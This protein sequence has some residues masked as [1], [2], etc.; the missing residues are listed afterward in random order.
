MRL[1]NTGSYE[2]KEFY[3]DVPKYAIL[4]HTWYSTEEEVIF[5]DLQKPEVAGEKTK[6]WRKVKRACAY[7]QMYQF[8][9]IW[10]DSCCINKESSAELSEAINSMFQYY[11][12]AEICYVYL[13][14]VLA[15]EDPRDVKS[16]FRQSRWFK[17]GWTLQ[18]LLA[19]AYVEFL[20][21]DW[22]KI[23][24]KWSLCDAISAI[25]TIPHPVLKNGDLDK[26]S[27]AQKMSWAAMRKTTRAEDQAYCLMGLFGVSMPPIYGEGGAKAFMRLQQEIIKISEDRSIFAWI[28]AADDGQPRGLLARSP[29][30]FR[31]SGDVGISD[32]DALDT[33]SSFSFNNNGL[34]IHLPLIPVKKNPGVFQASLH[35]R[36]GGDGR[37]LS[38]YLQEVTASSGANRYVRSYVQEVRLSSSPPTTDPKSLREVVIKEN[39]LSQRLMRQKQSSLTLSPQFILPESCT[40]CQDLDWRSRPI[41]DVSNGNSIYSKKEIFRFKIQNGNDEEHFSIAI[42]RHQE[43]HHGTTFRLFTETTEPSV[44]EVTENPLA[45]F[46]TSDDRCYADNR[47]VPLKNGGMLVLDLHMTGDT[48]HQENITWT[49]MFEITRLPK[50]SSGIS[51]LTKELASPNLGF[52]APGETSYDHDL[53]LLDSVFPPDYYQ[54]IHDKETYISLSDQASFRVLTYKPRSQVNAHKI[55]V[56]SGFYETKPWTDVMVL[57]PDENNASD[58][59]IWR[60]YLDGGSRAQTRLQPQDSTSFETTRAHWSNTLTVSVRERSRIQLGTHSLSLKFKRQNFFW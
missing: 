38:I 37:Y 52:L 22:T 45:P 39:Q 18:E 43:P 25:T 10:I 58:E 47:V 3:T 41:R 13:S 19:P 23:G 15:K 6:G 55:F 5:Q 33:K 46:E 51:V 8:E 21:E 32:S 60:S 27:I 12:D 56:I 11:I 28:A 7:A 26:Y 57:N 49:I 53:F 35:C 31:S 42:E 14:D 44:F 50:Q 36:S 24:T 48:P 54:V 2:L 59:D 1:L 20:S 29:Y 30:E 40:R 16:T 17:R 34:H 9:W 4:S